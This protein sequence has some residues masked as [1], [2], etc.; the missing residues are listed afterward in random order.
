MSKFIIGDIVKLNVEP[1]WEGLIIE[2]LPLGEY[3]VKFLQ[4]GTIDFDPDH[5][6]YAD[7]DELSFIRKIYEKEKNK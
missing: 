6:S 5:Y 7:D 1:F 3:K 4:E 2:V